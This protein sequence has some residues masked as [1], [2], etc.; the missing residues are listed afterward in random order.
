MIKRFC[1]ALAAIVSLAGCA[2]LPAVLGGTP[3]GYADRTVLDEQGALFANLTYTAASKGAALAIRTGI[4]KSPSAI[5]RIGYLDAKAYAAVDAV[6]RAY[7]S[8]N[9]ASYAVA[10]DEAKRTLADLTAAF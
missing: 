2:T 9:A 1:L 5:K 7:A 4:I 10:L 3:A 8:L 6:N